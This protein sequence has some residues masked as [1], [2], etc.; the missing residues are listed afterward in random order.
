VA[1]VIVLDASVLIAFL[2]GGDAHHEAARALLA[3]HVDDDLAVHPLNLAETLVGPVRQG[4]VDVALRALRD[5]EVTALSSPADSALRLAE[6]RAS[7]NL[8]MPDCCVLLAAEQVGATVASFDGR[9][10]AAA[11]H[12]GLAALPH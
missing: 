8:R 1:E 3:E 6:L 5:L 10:N 9:L 4:R 2:D 7:T 12:R 11:R